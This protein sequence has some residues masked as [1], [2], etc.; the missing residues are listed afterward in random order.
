MHTVKLQD[1]LLRE[2]DVASLPSHRERYRRLSQ[3]ES[4]E[5]GVHKWGLALS[6]I[7]CLSSW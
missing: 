3:E 7:T 1:Q 5:L 6:Q 2:K 4:M